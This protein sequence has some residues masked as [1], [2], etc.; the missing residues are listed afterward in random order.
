MRLWTGKARLLK[1]LGPQCAISNY[2]TD[3]SNK[4]FPYHIIPNF[5]SFCSLQVH[6]SLFPV[7]SR[8]H[9]WFHSWLI[10]ASVLISLQV[11]SQTDL[12][13]TFRIFL[14]EVLEDFDTKSIQMLKSLRGISRPYGSCTINYSVLRPRHIF[15]IVWHDRF[16]FRNSRQ[17]WRD[18]M[19]QL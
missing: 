7:L 5:S 12:G 10:V 4:R 16:P 15:D 1:T 9:S 3:C 2:F 11:V 17:S 19:V 13:S 6:L 18:D 14:S 8:I